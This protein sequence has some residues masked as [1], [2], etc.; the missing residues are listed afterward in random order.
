MSET[1][2]LRNGRKGR[3]AAPKQKIFTGRNENG[4]FDSR[5]GFNPSNRHDNGNIAS[6]G[7]NFSVRDGDDGAIVV[8]FWNRSAVQP[9]VNRRAD[10]RRRHD[11]PDRQR[12]SRPRGKN[13]LAR[14]VVEL[15]FS[16][17]QIVCNTNK[18]PDGIKPYF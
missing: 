5:S 10:F 11:K 1:G 15:A 9:R 18:H 16:V 13:P 17:S 14:P 6:H 4:K 2:E 7:F 12:Q 3:R 8:V